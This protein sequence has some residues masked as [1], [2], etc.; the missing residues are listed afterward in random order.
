MK[1]GPKPTPTEDLES[2]RAENRARKG[3]MKVEQ[4]ASCPKPPAWLKAR[5]RYYW[6]QVAPWL[7]GN[8]MLA[9]PDLPALGVICQRMAD[10]ERF[11]ALI[12]GEELIITGDGIKANPL[13]RSRDAA[14]A[15]LRRLF[16]DMGMTPTARIGM[17]KMDRPGG[18]VIDA[19]GH[20]KKG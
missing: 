7:H 5:A 10:V 17:P 11:N 19:T 9:E 13:I 16:A 2:W 1:T 14:I 20:F 4:L 15:D 18:Q 12:D 8:K 3:E 6:Q